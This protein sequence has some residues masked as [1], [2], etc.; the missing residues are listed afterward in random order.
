MFGLP[1]PNLKLAHL[2]KNRAKT[3]HG[4]GASKLLNAFEI[5]QDGEHAKD[6]TIPKLTSNVNLIKSQLTNLS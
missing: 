2:P 5:K 1:I 3:A 4:A 6:G